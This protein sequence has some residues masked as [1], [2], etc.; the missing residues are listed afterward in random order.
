MSHYSNK[1]NIFITIMRVGSKFF[2][3]R[4]PAGRCFLIQIVCLPRNCH[5]APLFLRIKRSEQI[6]IPRAEHRPYRSIRLAARV[7][8]FCASSAAVRACCWW[9][10]RGRCGSGCANRTR[11]PSRPSSRRIFGAV[12]SASCDTRPDRRRIWFALT[13]ETKNTYC[14]YHTQK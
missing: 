5:S 4:V 7:R 6:A 12:L 14:S 10:A 8:G 11:T 1:Y 9:S 3:M 2:V 13:P